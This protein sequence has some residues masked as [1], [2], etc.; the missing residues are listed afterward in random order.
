MSSPEEMLSQLVNSINLLSS[1]V[2]TISNTLSTFSNQLNLMEEKI[3]QLSTVKQDLE[4]LD[5]KVEQ[6]LKQ[7]SDISN[8]PEKL[9]AV[10]GLKSYV[11]EKLS[12][13]D[14]IPNIEK[15]LEGNTAL[16]SNLPSIKDKLS[17][18]EEKLGSISPERTIKPTVVTKE[19]KK[20]EPVIVPSSKILGEKAVESAIEKPQTPPAQ[21]TLPQEPKPETEEKNIELEIKR[22]E[23]KFKHVSQM[24][25]SPQSNVVTISKYL[26][27]LR[28]E[29]ESTVGMSPML[30]ELN[31]W[32]KKV[33]KMPESDVLLPDLHGELISKLDD[34]LTRVIN[35]MRRK[36]G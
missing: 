15:L 24:I 23:N 29:L 17:E 3:T 2:Q 16:L 31:A 32:I 4:G 34:W 19:Q 22:I 5:N 21:L 9:A 25:S 12:L 1:V 7:L 13:I 27:E 6:L 33:S 28:D 11:D 26:S 36:L 14:I 10:D 18:I 20:E 30:Y 35:A 8:L